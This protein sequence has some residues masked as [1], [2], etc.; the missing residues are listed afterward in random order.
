MTMDNM[1]HCALNVMT[2]AEERMSEQD[3]R[4]NQTELGRDS[5]FDLSTIPINKIFTLIFVHDKDK[6]QL[7]LGEKQRGPLLGQWNGF[8]GK[9]E[10]YIKETIAESADRELAEEAFVRATPNLLP[11]GHIQWVVST[12][13]NL[14]Q[15]SSNPQKQ[16]YR[17]V[18]IV[19]KAHGLE[20]INPPSSPTSPTESQVLSTGLSK[21]KNKFIPSDEMAPAWWP[22]DKLPWESMRINHKVW[23]PYMLS[24]RPYRGVY[25]YNVTLDPAFK[26]ANA[27][28]ENAKEIWVED[29][30][31]RRVQFG[32][33]LSSEDSSRVTGAHGELER[34]TSLIF[35][36]QDSPLSSS[37][38]MR[39]VT[40]AGA[41]VECAT[42]DMDWL[43]GAVKQAERDFGLQ[44]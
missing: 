8:G 31:K 19:Y 22:V 10:R 38:A 21:N 39:E 42:M 20:K 7:L 34:Y 14:S 5:G 28:R 18:M 12:P 25:W 40:F 17:D 2:T 23:Y 24:D 37:E 32:P 4:D 29:L 27:Q 15:S 36:I 3:G 30:K 16:S 33:Q 41:P 6:D 43:V 35:G 13:S 44:A 11:I 9:V 26:A 1:I